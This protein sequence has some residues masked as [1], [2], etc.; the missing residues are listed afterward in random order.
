MPTIRRPPRRQSGGSGERSR[1]GEGPERNCRARA[2]GG[3]QYQAHRGWAERPV[4]RVRAHAIYALGAIGP[5][6]KDSVPALTEM[7]K[8]P[9][10]DVRRSALHALKAIIPGRS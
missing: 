4:A 3:R 1:Q 10:A 2:Q 9:D 5:A 6:A 7:L 8:D